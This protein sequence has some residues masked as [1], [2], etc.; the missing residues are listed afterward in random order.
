MLRVTLFVGVFGSYR[1]LLGDEDFS[2]V[3]ILMT[4]FAVLTVISVA[5]QMQEN[6]GEH[7]YSALVTFC[8]WESWLPSERSRFATL[9][10]FTRQPPEVLVGFLIRTFKFSSKLSQLWCSTLKFTFPVNYP[11]VSFAYTDSELCGFR[12]GLLTASALNRAAKL[13][14]F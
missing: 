2:Y 5:A 9:L 7:F 4:V 3:V 14:R 10:M 13:H 12:N 11:Y 6:A 8:P 1:F